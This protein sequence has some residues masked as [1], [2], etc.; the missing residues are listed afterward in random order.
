MTEDCVRVSGG[1]V[2]FK[3]RLGQSTTRWLAGVW[4]FRR[5]EQEAS[6]DG[7]HRRAMVDKME[8]I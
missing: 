4:G 8:Q 1:S 3:G 2:Y 6:R 7:S 5:R